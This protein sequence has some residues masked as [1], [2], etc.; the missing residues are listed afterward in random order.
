MTLRPLLLGFALLLVAPLAACTEEEAT[1]SAPV[2]VERSFEEHKALVLAARKIIAEDP[3]AALITVDAN[4]LPRARTVN[5]R[6]PDIDMVMWIATK[7]NTRKVEQIR[8]NP[9]VTLYFSNDLKSAYVTVMGTAVL[10]DDMESIEATS[11]YPENQ[12]RTFWPDFPKDYLLIEVKPIWF[13][14]LGHGIEANEETWR[15]QAVVIEK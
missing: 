7:P 3:F 14:V 8:A 10:H 11:W 2:A 13:E 15:P 9:N 1:V 6:P 4:G 12:L 5:V